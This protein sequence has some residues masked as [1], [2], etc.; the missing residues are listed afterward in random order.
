MSVRERARAAMSGMLAGWANYSEPP[1]ISQDGRYALL[2]SYYAGTWRQDPGIMAAMRRRDPALYRNTRQLLKR[3]DAIVSL[4]DQYCYVGEL[5]TDGSPLQDGSPSAIPVMPETGSQQDNDRLVLALHTLWSMWGWQ[6][7][8][9]MLPR[10]AAILGDVMIE[11]VP[12]LEHGTVMPRF[13][14]PGLIGDLVL[15][16]AG[17]V[18][19]YSKTY[20]VEVKASSGAFGVTRE[21][22]TYWFRKEVDTAWIRY[23]KDGQPFDYATNTF[24]GP[25]AVQENVYQ[26]CPAVWCRHEVLIDSVRGMGAFEKTLVTSMEL[27]ST[28]SAALDYSL[29]NFRSPVGVADADDAALTAMRGRT[30]TLPGGTVVGGSVIHSDRA[31]QAARRAAQ[32]NMDLLPMGPNGKFVTVQF[33]IGSTKDLLELL[34]DS[35]GNENPESEYG[36]KLLE[37]KQ[38]TGPGVS[39]ILSP[40]VGKVKG[41]RKNHDPRQEQL[42]QMGV[43]MMGHHLAAG[44]FDETLVQ[45]R[46]NRYKPFEG[47]DLSSFG[48]GKLDWKVGSR[49]VFA[50]TQEERVQWLVMAESLTSRWAMLQAGIPEKEVDAILGEREAARAALAD[51]TLIDD[52]DQ[53]D[54]RQ[55]RSAEAQ[56]ARSR[57]DVQA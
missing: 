57:Q 53:Q 8:M 38:G 3:T 22:E 23:Y 49:P 19:Q 7:Q 51:A 43:A 26:F 40:I 15:D 5:S 42:G 55:D 14:W 17:N 21:A 20:R 44:D 33:D 30:I 18:K 50:E 1:A 13:I 6:Q 9:N 28:M 11:L 32:E 34:G 52:L 25:G 47:Y 48:A 45:A 27:N 29:K 41:A 37:L 36:A 2:W 10:Y 56:T 39:R 35:L 46:P 12:D 24:G 54:T 4:Y 16:D 31:V